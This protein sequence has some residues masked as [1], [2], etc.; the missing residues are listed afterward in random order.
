[1]LDLYLIVMRVVYIH[2]REILKLLLFSLQV[3]AYCFIGFSLLIQLVEYSS[4][5]DVDP[6]LQADFGQTTILRN[7]LHPL[8]AEV[9]RLYSEIY[10]PSFALIGVFS[11]FCVVVGSFI[12]VLFGEGCRCIHVVGVCCRSVC[13]G[14][15]DFSLHV[16]SKWLESFLSLREPYTLP[17][18]SCLLVGLILGMPPFLRGH[19]AIH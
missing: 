15:V 1:M 19:F 16:G 2:C 10:Q 14:E 12:I 3:S 11:C 7:S 18:R 17:E 8:R 13:F 5:S 6:M 9:V 4:I